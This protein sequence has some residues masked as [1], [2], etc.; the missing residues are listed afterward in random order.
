MKIQYVYIGVGLAAF[1]VVG[2]VAIL[3]SRSKLNVD[4]SKFD[5][6]DM[7]GSGKCMDKGFIKMLSRIQKETKLPIFQWINSGARS[8][9]WNSKVGGVN[10]SAHKMPKCK[11][12]DIK[13]PTKEIRDRIIKAAKKVGFRRIGIGSNFVHLDNDFTKKQFVA[14][15]YPIGSRPP[16]NPFA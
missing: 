16:I 12:A 15:G 14:W 6:P 8:A 1:I 2:G 10:S 11:A 4:L 9:Y 7:P 13:A 3:L 5:S